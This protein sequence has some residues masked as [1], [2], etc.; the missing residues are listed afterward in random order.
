MNNLVGGGHRLRGVY[1]CTIMHMCDQ[2][3]CVRSYA[4]A[5]KHAYAF[6]RTEARAFT[7]RLKGVSVVTSSEPLCTPPGFLAPRR[8]QSHHMCMHMYMGRLP[9]CGGREGVL[10]MSV[11]TA[12]IASTLTCNMTRADEARTMLSAL[13]PMIASQLSS[14]CGARV[15]RILMVRGDARGHGPRE[16]QMD[17]M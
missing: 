17:S 7:D 5:C 8:R 12:E 6:V 14:R 3:A 13:R 10:F 9:V 15:I 1:I 11:P 16:G 2:H 4:Y